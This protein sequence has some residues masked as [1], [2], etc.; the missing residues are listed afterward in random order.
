MSRR[1]IDKIYKEIA[2]RK[3][4]NFLKFVIIQ[5]IIIKHFKTF[6]TLDIY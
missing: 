4:M 5:N 3:E 6:S 2:K 1:Y